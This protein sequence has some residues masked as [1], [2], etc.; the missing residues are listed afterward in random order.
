MSYTDHHPNKFLLRGSQEKR[1]HH[2]KYHGTNHQ[3]PGDR[4]NQEG[5]WKECNHEPQV[6]LEW[7]QLEPV[8]DMAERGRH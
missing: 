2:T 8:R 1:H 4:G 5:P 3:L 6:V 7:G